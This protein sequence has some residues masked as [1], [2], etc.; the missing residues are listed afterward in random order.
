MKVGKS[1]G[2]ALRFVGATF[3]CYLVGSLLIAGGVWWVS[4]PA[5]LIA[6]GG[7]MVGDVLL[8]RVEKLVMY[9]ATVQQKEHEP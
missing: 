3:I 2:A 1:I 7:M 8:G 5:G 9:R 6:L 4:P